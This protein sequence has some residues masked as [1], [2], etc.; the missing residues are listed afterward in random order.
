LRAFVE[1]A[2]RSTNVT[3]PVKSQPLKNVTVPLSARSWN[4]GVT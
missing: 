3:F 1:A 4:A 2:T